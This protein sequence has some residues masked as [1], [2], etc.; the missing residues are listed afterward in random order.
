M[1]ERK[2]TY[3]IRRENEY[4]VCLAG[5]DYET[6][7]EKMTPRFSIYKY[8]AARI[9]RRTVAWQIVQML[10]KEGEKWDFV[11]FQTLDGTVCRL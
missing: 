7:P 10:K 2:T 5:K 1:R 4:L 11:R 8:D 9:P 6:D 3:L